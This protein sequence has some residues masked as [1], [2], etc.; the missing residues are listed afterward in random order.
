VS[1]TCILEHGVRTAL[2]HVAV[3]AVVERDGALLLVQRAAALPQGG[4]WGLPGGFLD[5]D[6]TLTQGV[7][8]ELREETGWDGRVTALLRI[9]S[10]PDRPHEDRQNVAFDFVVAPLA[11]IGEPDAESTRVQWFAL[12]A[13]PPLETL[14][15]DHGDTVRA[16]LEARGRPAAAPILL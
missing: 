3:H 14:A 7:V 8:R 6:E 5:R 11:K 15:F 13:L 9:N 4:K 1:I 10:R 12:D 2:R 16:Y